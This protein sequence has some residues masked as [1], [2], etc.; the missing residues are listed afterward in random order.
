[1][2]HYKTDDAAIIHAA[3]AEVWAALL[4][5]FAGETHWWLPEL[6]F[7]PLQQPATPAVG[8]EIEVIPHVRGE[9]WLPFSLAFVARVV[10]LVENERLVAEYVRG[11]YRGRGE[12]LLEPVDEG[13]QLRMRWQVG[14]HGLLP[15]LSGLAVDAGSIHSQ[16]MQTGFRRLDAVLA[17][18]R[19][20]PLAE[21]TASVPA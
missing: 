16:M 18:A 17:S 11:A 5:E 7:R 12:W 10:D 19:P 9:R 3:A 20:T 8:T 6:E 2:A 14:S 15:T 21:P 13:T 4:R 1:M